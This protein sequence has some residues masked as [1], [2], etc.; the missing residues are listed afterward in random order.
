MRAHGTYIGWKASKIGV[1]DLEV[2]TIKRFS[3]LKV[4]SLFSPVALVGN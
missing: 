2:S 3:L 1:L 4:L